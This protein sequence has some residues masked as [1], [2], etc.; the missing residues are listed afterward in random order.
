MLIVEKKLLNGR[1]F[2]NMT[3][4]KIE[5]CYYEMKRREIVNR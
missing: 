3:T 2:C 5:N 4:K 1:F